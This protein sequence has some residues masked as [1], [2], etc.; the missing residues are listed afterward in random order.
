VTTTG[1]A[2]STPETP[3]AEPERVSPEKPP[4]DTEMGLPV[5]QQDNPEQLGADGD[6]HSALGVPEYKSAYVI[7]ED[8]LGNA[9]VGRGAD[10][11][12]EALTEQKDDG[13]A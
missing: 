6:V 3:A 5:P 8:D 1:A 2:V 7:E 12:T 9:S 10:G 4:E 11:N 13:G